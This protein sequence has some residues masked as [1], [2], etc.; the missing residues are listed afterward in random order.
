MTD[1]C[2]EI[3]NVLGYTVV[4]ILHTNRGLASVERLKHNRTNIYPTSEDLKDSGWKIKKYLL[5]LVSLKVVSNENSN[6]CHI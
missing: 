1:Y 2:V 3:K 5:S 4:P 6:L